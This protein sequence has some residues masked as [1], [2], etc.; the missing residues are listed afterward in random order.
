MHFSEVWMAWD[1]VALLVRSGQMR[2]PD[3]VA[4]GELGY[5]I[6]KKKGHTLR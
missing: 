6:L 3:D 1:S 4:A 5:E 2:A